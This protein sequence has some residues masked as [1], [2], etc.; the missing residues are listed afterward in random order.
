MK[1]VFE[2]RHSG[3]G[4]G[5]DGKSLHIKLPE[6]VSFIL[7]KL[8]EHGHEAYIVGGCVRDSVLNRTPD[9]WDITTS[10]KPEEV[11]A[12]FRRTVD[13]GIQHG[14]VTVIRDRKGYEVTTYRIDGVYE[15]NRRPKEVTFT[16]SL[17]EDLKRRDFTVNAMAYNETEGLID[18]FGG[19]A[20]IRGKI[21]R[22]VGDAGQR[23]EEDAL[24]IM[25]AVRFSAQLGYTIE[26]ETAAA[27]AGLADNLRFVSAERIQTELTKLL[28]SSYPEYLK[29]AWELGIT[30]RILPE[31][32]KAME[33]PQN[34]PYHCCSVGEHLLRAMQYV[35]ADKVLRLT[36]LMHDLGKTRV[37]STDE[38]GR[39]HFY[40][41]GAESE[42][43]AKHIL[44]RLRYDNDTIDKVT[45]LVRYHDME[46]ALTPDK[47]RKAMVR[48][49][50]ELFPLLLTVKQAD[51]M[52]Q[53]QYRRK[54]KESHLYRLKQLHEESIAQGNCIRL[55]DMAVTG[56]DLIEAGM[57]PGRALGETLEEL[58]QYVLEFPEKNQKDIL[59]EQ[60]GLQ[61]EKPPSVCPINQGFK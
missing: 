58:F 52:A 10:A 45:R 18:L 5:K 29:R 11:K 51:M 7:R 42:A 25:R 23:F 32:D 33:T 30:A 2:K 31:F 50:I 47:V 55:Q 13:T 15:D 3:I 46:I 19:M 9:D 49:G 35:P 59:L 36:M 37:R 39:D 12:I 61:V 8:A 40:G 53:S 1:V 41:H 4:T 17:A 44:K 54:E 27:A 48:V 21:L 6:N 16:A 56:K 60:A 57:K 14:T 22:C 20:D 43:M 28:C 26:K 34:T 38:T 24:R